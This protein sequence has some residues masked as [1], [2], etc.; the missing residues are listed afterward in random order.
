MYVCIECGKKYQG[1]FNNKKAAIKLK[2]LVDSYFCGH[3][4][5]F[6]YYICRDIYL[7]DTFLNH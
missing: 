3:K 4:C 5:Y 7:K 6:E 1:I 2:F